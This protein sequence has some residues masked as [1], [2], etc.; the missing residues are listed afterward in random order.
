MTLTER[1]QTW[2][3]VTLQ[4]TD[5]TVIFEKNVLVLYEED[6]YKS[7]FTFE[8]PIYVH[9]GQSITIGTPFAEETDAESHDV[10]R[11][12]SRR[13]NRDNPE[14]QGDTPFR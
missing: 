1:M 7:S 4:K 9:S 6:G 8:K 14:N 3:G 11:A 5:G 10:Q 2:R 12:I 13:R